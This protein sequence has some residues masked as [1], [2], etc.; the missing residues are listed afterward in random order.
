MVV[1]CTDDIAEVV[2]AVV[3]CWVCWVCSAWTRVCDGDD[4]VVVSVVDVVDTGPVCACSGGDCGEVI[5]VEFCGGGVVTPLEVII[6]SG[7]SNDE[8]AVDVLPI[9]GVVVEIFDADVVGVGVWIAGEEE[10]DDDDNAL[11]GGFK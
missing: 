6:L 9:E 2:V 8:T 7:F 11:E 10:E 5:G 4:S 1:D 3:V